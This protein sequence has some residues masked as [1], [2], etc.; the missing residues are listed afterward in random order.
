MIAECSSKP[1]RSVLKWPHLRPEDSARVAKEANVKRLVLTHFDAHLYQT[2]D[3]RKKA[4]AA[5]KRIFRKTIAAYDGLEI[6][7]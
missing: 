5:A 1:D 4:E 2:L 3:D 6:E 7:V